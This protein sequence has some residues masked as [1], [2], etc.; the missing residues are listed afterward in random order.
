MLVDAGGYRFDAK[1]L[2]PRLATALRLSTRDDYRYLARFTFYDKKFYPTESFLDYAMSERVR[3]GDGYTIS[4]SIES[5][6]RNDDALDNRLGS[7]L[8]PTLLIWGQGDM[9]VPVECC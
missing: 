9:L 2:S 1:A 7:I 5:L 8:A 6:L 3:R 4:K